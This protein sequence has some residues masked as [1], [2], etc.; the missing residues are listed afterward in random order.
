MHLKIWLAALVLVDLSYGGGFHDYRFSV[1][2]EQ[3]QTNVKILNAEN[4]CVESEKDSSHIYAE[5]L[6]FPLN[7]GKFY[8]RSKAKGNQYG[9]Y[10]GGIKSECYKKLHA[11]N[12]QENHLTALEAVHLRFYSSMSSRPFQDESEIYFDKKYLYSSRVPNLYFMK[13]GKWQKLIPAA[14]TGVVVVDSLPEGSFILMDAEKWKTPL[15][16]ASVDTGLFYATVFVPGYYP[17]MASL[18][19]SS[20]NTS[21]L[22]TV[23][24]PLDTLVYRIESGVT[25]ERIQS[26]QNLEETEALYDRF[27]ADLE[28]AK[29][30]RSVAPFD[31]IY[32]RAKRPPSGMDS[33]NAQY[34]AYLKAY[35]GVRSRAQA[36]WLSGRLSSILQINNALQAR[37]DFFQKDTIHL[38]ADLKSIDW[39]DSVFTFRLGDSTGRIDVTSTGKLQPEMDV[40]ASVFAA[41]AQEPG[42][43]RFTLTLQNKP[44]WKYEGSKVKTRHHYRF[45]QLN[46][47][48]RGRVYTGS[49]EFILPQDIQREPEVQEWLH[50]SPK[51]TLI[52]PVPE[53]SDDTSAAI[54]D[55]LEENV[56][57]AVAYIDSGTFRYKNKI[58]RMSPFRIRKTEVT[59]G[60]YRQVMKDSTTKF[61]F[62]DS[63]MPAHNVNWDKARKFCLAVG[64]DLP[65][66]SQWEFAARAGTNEGYIWRNR[67]GALPFEY[68]VY[69]ADAPKR[70]AS[71]KPNAWGLYDVSGNVAEWTLDSYSWFSFYVE[72]ENP[73]GSFFG[74]S[75]VFKGGSWKSRSDDELDLTD[76]DDEDPRY[77]SNALGFRCV[78]PLEEKK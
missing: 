67:N 65:T 19:V 4:M 6:R 77:W 2:N 78:F 23:L 49:G 52:P 74:D 5:K 48:Y 35:Q 41:E 39:N 56:S 70:V 32:P 69:R 38:N 8:L 34:V 18:R 63:L 14:L 57:R 72:S 53:A 71:A 31:S 1:P 66:E 24:I 36:Q 43:A 27:I 17:Y 60:E 40:P 16:I 64:G 50:P 73:T 37:L 47:S 76:R 12:L 54:R 55:S 26:A 15:T 30:D 22:K 3:F 75:R 28:A 25:L 42:R 45:T 9:W 13:N 51:D 44:L 68:A 33:S 20:G 58:V 59:V 10:S 11:F 29:I 46:V 61:T 21:R 62:A 7:K